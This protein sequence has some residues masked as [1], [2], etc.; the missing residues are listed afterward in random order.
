MK[1]TYF[2]LTVLAMAS[3][4][5][6]RTNEIEKDVYVPKK[7][8]IVFRLANSNTRSSEVN[9]SVQGVS[10]PLGEDGSGNKLYLEETI[11]RLEEVS[12]ESFGAATKGTPA[13]T[14][15]FSDLYGDFKAAAFKTSGGSFEATPFDDGVFE[16]VGNNTWKRKFSDNWKDQFPFY[17]FLR[18]PYNLENQAVKNLKYNTSDGSITFDYDGS[19]LKSASA[20]KDLLFTSR[21]VEEDEYD[22]LVNKAEAI[23]IL[24]HHALTGVKF[25]NAFS[26]PELDVKTY[27]TKVEIKGLADG[28]QCVLT[29]RQETN[30]YVDDKAK[31][32]S[33]K[34]VAVWAPGKLSYNDVVF[35]QTFDESDEIDFA[36]EGSFGANGSYTGTTFGKAGNENNLN[37]ADGSLT[38]WFVPQQLTKNVEMTV[39]YKVINT[40]TKAEYEDHDTIKF[41]DLTRT[42]TEK[43]VTTTE[44]E[45]DSAT[46]TTTTEIEYG[47]Y[48]NW[49]AGELRTYTLKPRYVEVDIVDELTDYEK[50][51]V[52][53]TNNGNVYEYVRV[54]IIGN[55]IGQVQTD[56]NKW[57]VDEDGK[58][59]ETVLMGYAAETGDALVQA[60]NDKDGVYKD[61]DGNVISPLYTVNGVSYD[62][63]GTFKGLPAKSN[64]SDPLPEGPAWVRYDKYYYYTKA[65]GP[66]ESITDPLFESYVVNVSPVFWIPDSWG[67][68]RNPRNVHLEMDLSVQAIPAPM[69]AEGNF[70]GNFI[71][72]WTEALDGKDLNDL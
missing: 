49:K 67:V 32:F 55:W 46:T 64:T 9:A 53:V 29:P 71:S 38:F 13:Y 5:G 48:A 40:K 69:D 34:T 24:F 30:G 3:L 23:P 10:I 19:G 25:A 17:F 70:V 47:A 33:S 28:G 27:I 66:N 7:G 50:T 61:K 43:E 42:K 56:E 31:D 20:Q 72:A 51:D 36:E 57:L 54:N 18:A 68:R 12:C 60:W 63:Y 65:I 11:T 6:C 8:E 15:N 35:T 22:A 52:V 4:A 21:L 1:K 26:N 62:M 2:V 37:K 39:Y 14:E 45:G 41:G 58:D 44:G 59:L 16:S